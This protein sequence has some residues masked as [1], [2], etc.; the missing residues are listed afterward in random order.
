MPLTPGA[1]VSAADGPN[2]RPPAAACSVAERLNQALAALSCSGLGGEPH[3]RATVAE[4]C[5][6]ACVSRNTLYRYYPD[7]LQALRRLHRQQQRTTPAEASAA[8]RDLRPELKSLQAQLNKLAALVDH[9]YAAYRETR[10]LLERRDR[11][12]AELRRGLKSSPT[13]L[14]R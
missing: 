3:D 12:I 4:L 1:G 9:Y 7:V 13:Q 2:R 8:S 5:R 11:E 10:A 14:R 6:R